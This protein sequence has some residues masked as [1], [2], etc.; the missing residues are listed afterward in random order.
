MD[1]SGRILCGGHFTAG[2]MCGCHLFRGLLDA[3]AGMGVL[4]RRFRCF[5][6]DLNPR[7][8][9]IHPSHCTECAV[10]Y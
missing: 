2:I 8:S 5:C 6:Q 9:S 4:E 3:G 1:V 7:S 10:P